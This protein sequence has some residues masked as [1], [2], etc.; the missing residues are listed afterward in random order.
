MTIILFLIETIQR[1]QFRSYYLQNKNIFQN[2]SHN[3]GNLV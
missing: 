2:F 3:V 1:N